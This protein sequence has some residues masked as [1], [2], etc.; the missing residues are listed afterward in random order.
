V[1]VANKAQCWPT[2]ADGCGLLP[3]FAA[4]ASC[5]TAFTTTTITDQIKNKK[6]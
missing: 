6:A 5:T 2:T 4:Q 3:T 1:G